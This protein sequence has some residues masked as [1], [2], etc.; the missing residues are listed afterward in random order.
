MP[1]QPTRKT[2]LATLDLGNIVARLDRVEGWLWLSPHGLPTETGKAPHLFDLSVTDTLPNRLRLLAD[3]IQ[4]E[5]PPSPE[6]RP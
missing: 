1:L 3:I 5:L 2:Q 4:D 6:A